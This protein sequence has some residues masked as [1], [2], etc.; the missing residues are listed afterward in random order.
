MLFR[1]KGEED[2]IPEN[3]IDPR[4]VRTRKLLI[5]SFTK[6]TLKKILKIL[7]FKT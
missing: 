6:L 3:K 7:Q 4:I 5:E 2:M 1:N